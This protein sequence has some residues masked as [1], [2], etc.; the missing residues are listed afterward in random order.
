LTRLEQSIAWVLRAGVVA[1]SACMAA[2]VVLS[3]TGVSPPLAGELLHVG[4]L[5]LLCTPVARVVIST[6]EYAAAR[7]WRF[8]T[9]TTIVL[10]ELM[11][12]AVAA[13]V[14]NRRL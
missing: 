4:L 11:A 10:L 7:D 5:I 8:A 1:S 9:L 13:L 12:S 2:G 14:F 3:L 6:I